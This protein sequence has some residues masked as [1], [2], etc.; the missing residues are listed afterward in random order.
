MNLKI[1]GN[2]VKTI[3][4]YDSRMIRA[5]NK[6]EGQKRWAANRSFTFENTPYNIEVW[7]SVFPDCV[8]EEPDAP[9]AVVE[10]AIFD[11]GVDRPA[12]KYKTPPRDH[13]KRALEKIYDLD[14]CGMFMDVGTGKSWTAI[15][16][17]GRRWCEGKIDCVLLVA[18]NGVH[19]QWVEEQIPAHMSESVKWKAW[20]WDKSK[21]G[22][23]KFEELMAFDGLKIFAINI[24][25]IIT[26]AGEFRIIQFLK[27]ANGKA[28][29]IVD[30][31][32]D[33]K[34]I[35]ANRT[36]AAIRYGN[37][38]KYRLI[39]T[40]TPIAKDVVDMFSQFKFLDERILGHRYLSTFKGRY[41]I[42]R[43][44]DFGPVVIGHQNIEELYHKVD[45]HIFRITSEEALDLPPKV[46]VQRPF[47]LSN[48]QNKLIKDLRQQFFTDFG[49]ND[50]SS[51]KNAASLLTRIQQISCGFL[52]PS[53][54]ETFFSV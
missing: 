16:I 46:Y 11:V 1:E 5:L 40:G 20:V 33:I 50:F 53:S 30:E 48:E 36:K 8:I 38:C 51:V 49:K 23:R 15:S 25:A 14:N 54:I 27:A 2:R 44:T 31:S 21:K 35:S 3:S 12:F 34:N 13:Q 42:F 45:P 22:E 6:L 7:K 24:D 52:P 4:D 19:A 28:M 10:E 26:P 41:C 29:M 32:Q 43:Q 47:T 9:T 18:K 37:I 39:M 17:V